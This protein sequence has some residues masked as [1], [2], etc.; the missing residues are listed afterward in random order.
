MRTTLTIDDDVA[1]LIERERQRTG[2]TLR[3][4]TNRLLRQGLQRRRGQAS[5]VELPTLSGRPRIDVTDTSAV[6]AD[7]DDDH[8]AA[9]GTY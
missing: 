7:T 4:A 3:Q 5:P 8:L 2:E 6:L 9:K 1:A